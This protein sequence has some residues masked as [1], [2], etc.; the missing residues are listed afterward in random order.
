[1]KLATGLLELTGRVRYVRGKM[2]P[3]SAELRS[4]SYHILLLEP[5]GAIKQIVS[6][7]FCVERIQSTIFKAACYTPTGHV[8]TYSVDGAVIRYLDFL[9]LVFQDLDANFEI[10]L[11]FKTVFL[12]EISDSFSTAIG[13]LYAAMQ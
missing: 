11:F 6:A 13:A 2:T 3:S 4:G 9:D 5:R 1:M 8:R 10:T 12:C 7:N